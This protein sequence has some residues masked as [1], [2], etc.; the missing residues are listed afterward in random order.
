MGPRPVLHITEPAMIRE[1]FANNYQF[2]K[3]RGRS[4]FI[5]LI[6]A[7]LADAEANQW[8]KHRKIIHPA[9]HIEKLKVCTSSFMYFLNTM[10]IIVTIIFIAYGPC[11][12][13]ELCR[14]DQKMGRNVEE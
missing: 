8:S 9:F 1:I 2:P 14:V 7:G 11:T 6:V 3:A 5:K 4:P 10:Q 12:L 13:Y